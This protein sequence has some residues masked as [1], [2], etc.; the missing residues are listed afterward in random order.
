[1]VSAQTVPKDL[2]ILDVTV[3]DGSYAIGHQYTA[4]DVSTIVETLDAAGIDYI[5]VS[6]GCGLGAKENF[7]LPAGASDAEYA[8]AAK[9]SAEN[10]KIGV[11]ANA[12]PAT[13]PRDI[14]AVIDTV[15]FIRFATNCDKPTAV[16][17]NIE[18][19][20][21]RKPDLTV[22]LQLMRCNRR[23][24]GEIAAAGRMAADMGIDLIYVVD[25]AGSLM[26]EDVRATVGAL[27][28]ACEARVGFH[29]HNN[30]GLAIANTL[31][32]VDAGAQTVDA[33]LRGMG[34]AGGNA[35][36]EALISLLNRRGMARHVDLDMVVAA[37]EMHIQP[38]MPAAA[39][40]AEIDVLTADANIDLYPLDVYQRLAAA[41]EIPLLELIRTLGADE[42]TVEVD[43]GSL[44]RA[45]QKFGKNPKAVLA[46]LGIET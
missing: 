17:S 9:N 12:A 22:F 1:M 28:D 18:Y 35:Q 23:A 43:V 30:L 37:G 4:E 11:I 16:S 32:A 26:P 19:A 7:G 13:Q 15:D 8:R 34:R 27:S 36:L 41:A 25:T 33:S 10:A 20:R 3:R 6:H 5:E 38:I 45:L 24:P 44:Q 14:D 29:G 40:I 39:G 21:K 42:L 2:S 46:S 31:A